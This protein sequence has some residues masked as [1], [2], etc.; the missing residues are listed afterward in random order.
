MYRHAAGY[1]AYAQQDGLRP[2]TAQRSLLDGATVC[3]L[4]SYPLAQNAPARGTGKYDKFREDMER[5]GL[6]VVTHRHRFYEGPA[7][8]VRDAE[9]QT[10][11]R[12][13]E[14]ELQ[15]EQLGGGEWFVYPR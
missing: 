7:V 1:T 15:W 10:A 9:L 8:R 14:L 4:C 6:R 13:T 5:A 2:H 12:C 11:F 3:A